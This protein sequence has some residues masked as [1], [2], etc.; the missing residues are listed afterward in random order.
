VPERITYKVAVVT[1]RALIGDGNSPVLL[2]SLLVTDSGPLQPDR[3]GCPTDL[4]RISAF[5]VAGARI[6]NTLPLHVTSAS[7]L[8]VFKQHLK[9]HLFC[10]HSPDFPQYDFSVVLAVSAA[11]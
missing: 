3:S 9:L 6:C 11:I 8:T 5:P 1:Y 10:F 4:H 7:S 2:T